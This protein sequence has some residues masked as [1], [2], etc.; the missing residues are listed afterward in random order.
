[1]AAVGVALGRAAE[2]YLP[3]RLSGM[4]KKELPYVLLAPP[5][6]VK[7]AGVFRSDDHEGIAH[8]VGLNVAQGA[9]GVGQHRQEI[10]WVVG[11]V[12]DVVGSFGGEDGYGAIRGLQTNVGMQG[13]PGVGVLVFSHAIGVGARMAECR[14]VGL[15]GNGPAQI[16]QGQFHGAADGGVGPPSRTEAIVA[17]VDVQFFDDRAADDDQRRVDA[18]RAHH[19]AEVEPF[20]HHGLDGRDDHGHMFREAA[21]HHR[22]HGDALHGGPAAQ[23]RQLRNHF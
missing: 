15:A 17:A 12:H 13:L 7:E 23:R 16:D 5:A 9:H 11:M 1:M 2:F 18:G 22:V 3:D 14:L 4:L 19:A 10:P 6:V 21:S 8:H 20:V